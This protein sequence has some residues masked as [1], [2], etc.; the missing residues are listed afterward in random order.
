MLLFR[1]KGPAVRRSG[2]TDRVGRLRIDS[3]PPF[4]YLLS[5][6]SIGIRNRWEG[7]KQK[8]YRIT[9]MHRLSWVPS[10]SSPPLPCESA[11]RGGSDDFQVRIR[12]GGR[13][14]ELSQKAR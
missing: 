14:S 12:G 10:G 7:M 6:I 11:T 8:G 1:G 13:L 9:E 5:E 3:V 2:D 4:S